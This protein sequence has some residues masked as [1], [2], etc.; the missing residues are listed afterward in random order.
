ML[1]QTF[2]LGWASMTGA[3]ALNT[4]TNEVVVHTWDLAQA[5]RQSP[6]WDDRVVR[7]AFEAIRQALPAEG[8]AERFEAARQ[9]VPEEWR[10]FPHPFAEAVA[11]PP[12][13]PLIDQLVAWNGRGP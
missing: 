7:V 13:A 5:T 11:V 8:R 2:D 4:Y 12:D 3:A 1:S 9:N 10:D 6:V